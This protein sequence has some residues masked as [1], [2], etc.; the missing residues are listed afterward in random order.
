MNKNRET[1]HFSTD[2]NWINQLLQWANYHYPYL[3][4]FNPNDLDYPFQGFS[5]IFLAGTKKLTWDEIGNNTGEKAGI[6]AYDLKNYF[7]KLTCQNKPIVDTPDCI[8]FEPDLKIIFEG[9]KITIHHPKPNFIYDTVRAQEIQSFPIN[10][11]S[12]IPATSKED[13]IRNVQHIQDNIREGDIYEMNY[14]MAFSVDFDAMDPVSTY[15]DLSKK[16]PMPFSS[17]FK[18]QDQYLIGASPERFLKKTGNQ[19]IAQPIKGTIKR[20][21]TPEEDSQLQSQL[22][23]SEKEKA[24]NLMIV[25]LMRNDLARISEVGSVK[26][27]ELFGVYGFKQV[28]QLIS[29]VSSTLPKELGFHEIIAKTFPMGSMTG[30]PKIKCMELIENYENFKRGWFSGAIGFIDEKGDFDLSVIIRSLV[31]DLKE[32]RMFFAVG[33]AITHDADPEYEYQ[34][35]LL[36]AKA[37]MEILDG[38]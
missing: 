33:S 29:T 4:Y 24:E 3:A 1:K 7:E 37:I 34:E 21:K 22:K 9:K 2:R 19:L 31:V 35:C 30:A 12:I 28:S 17:F 25:D 15:F 36:K 27:E 26:V 18:A 8:F 14:C 10:P 38:H 23:N 6:L 13:Y 5:H 20:G 32:K 11:K 16:S